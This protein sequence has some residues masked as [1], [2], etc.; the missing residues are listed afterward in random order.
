MSMVASHYCHNKCLHHGCCWALMEFGKAKHCARCSVSPPWQRGSGQE[1][2]T[3]KHGQKP[4][5]NGFWRSK[6]E[7]TGWKKWWL[8][9]L[10]YSQAWSSTPLPLFPFLHLASPIVRWYQCLCSTLIVCSLLFCFFENCSVHYC[11]GLVYR[12]FLKYVVE[13]WVPFL[14]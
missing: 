11:D 14:F 5:L 4:T 13:G 9:L 6:E 3:M 10:P 1:G 2:N 12:M 7:G 8:T